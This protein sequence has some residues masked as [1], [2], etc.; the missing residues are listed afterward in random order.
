[1]LRA[2][3]HFERGET[4]ELK[5]F[6]TPGDMMK[7]G[8]T[9]IL[10]FA[11]Y[12]VPGQAKT[13][14][15]PELGAQLAARL[16]RRMTEHTVGVGRAVCR[17]GEV[18]ATVCF[19]GA[20]RRDFRAWLGDGLHYAMQPPGDLGVCLRS[21]FET[22]FLKGAERALAIGSDAPDLSPEILSHAVDSL[23]RH[24]VVIGPAADGGYYLIGMTSSRPELF[25][26]VDWGTERVYAQTCDAVKR[27]GLTVAEL[28][29]INDVDR[30]GDLHI[31]RNHPGLKDV[32]VEK[33]LISV[34]IPTLNES[35]VLGRTLERV[36]RADGIEVIVSDGGSQDA[37]AG[38][39]SAAGATVMAVSGGRAA[40]MNAAAASA[41]GQILLFLH[42]DTL[43][44]AGYDA[45]IRR[46][47][48]NPSVVAGAFKFQTDGTGI[49]MRLVEWAANFRSSIMNWPYGDQG[50]FMEK[51]IFEES[52]G[53]A[54]LAIMEDFELVRRLRRRGS[55]VTLDNP[56]VTSAR[57]WRKLGV[58]RTALLNQCM[59]AGFFTGVEPE[60]LSRLY[61][62]LQ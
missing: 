40:Q 28:P 43:L 31:I 54:H 53:F 36:C 33:P 57:R 56:A 55:V 29:E 47:L 5:I 50:L 48:D 2:C 39:A 46:A 35:A 6:G 32:F 10:L 25:A 4:S 44:P 22:A 13:R 23:H 34:I 12:P 30:P 14:L 16:H 41:K 17:S 45:L 18:E 42:A 58:F 52:G 37:T 27:Y 19:T 9:H 24:D 1:M 61:R 15:V 3:C 49:A 7:R 26:S 20:R 38:I 62:M 11:R 51:R 21:A 60:R 59:V 8:G